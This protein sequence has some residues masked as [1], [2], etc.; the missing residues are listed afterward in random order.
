MAELFLGISV[1]FMALGHMFKVKRWKLFIAV[2]E[3]P[4]EADLL[5]ALSF[6]HTINAILPIRVGDIIRVLWAG[7]KMKNGCAFS[8]ATV[9]ADLYVDLITVGAMFWGLRIIGKGGRELQQAAYMYM[10][11]FVLLVCITTV[12][13]TCRKWIKKMIG[14]VA[15]LFNS[16]IEFALLYVTYLSIA[17]V[18]DIL[19]NINKK[20]FVY[21][22]AI[23]FVQN[24]C[25]PRNHAVFGVFPFQIVCPVLA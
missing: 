8:A 19:R 10:Y 4:S 13:V 7:R 6:G 17:S 14:S 22:T 1:I 15:A 23:I 9:I 3:E 11:A 24:S 5:N 16:K 18:K 12:A 21:Y 25:K 2:Y 20:R